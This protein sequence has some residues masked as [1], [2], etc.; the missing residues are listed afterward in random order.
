M[1]PVQIYIFWYFYMKQCHNA[2][3]E[4]FQVREVWTDLAQC[5]GRVRREKHK[6]EKALATV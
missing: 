2:P 6:I 3:T 5:D 1:N 4:I